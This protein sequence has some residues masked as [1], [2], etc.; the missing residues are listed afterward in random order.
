MGKLTTFSMAF[1]L[2]IGLANPGYS[3]SFSVIYTFGT[4]PGDP[5]FPFS[6]PPGIVIQGRD[7]DLYTTSPGGGVHND[8]TV[9]TLT[10]AGTLDVFYSFNARQ[11]PF[12]QQPYV[13]LALGTD[14]V[15]YGSTLYGGKTSGG[16]NGFGTVFSVTSAGAISTLYSFSGALDGANP[17]AP[18]I[19]GVDGNW[20]GTTTTGTIP[21]GNGTTFGGT[22]YKLT[23]AGTLTTLYMFETKTAAPFGTLVQGTDGKFY[24]TSSTGG[25]NQAG[26]IF[27]ITP[28][29]EFTALYTF[30][31]G[32]GGDFPEAGL[33]QGSDGNFYG[34]TSSGTT[35]HGGAI[36]RITPKGSLT[37]LHRFDASRDSTDG[38]S[39]L[40]VVQAT[41][42]NLYGTTLAGGNT[43]SS[44][45]GGCGT[46][47]RITPQ[48]SNYSI[49]YNFNTTTGQPS[50]TPMQHTSGKLYAS[51]STPSGHGVVYSLDVGL[52]P[53]VTFLQRQSL[54]KVGKTIGIFGQGFA[55]ASN[56]SFDGTSANFQVKSDTYLITT[57]PS[58][59]TTGY[60]TITTAMGVLNSSTKFRIIQ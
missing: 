12:L 5:L 1:L 7:G 56:V 17:F 60:V 22:I 26:Q 55:T 9:F 3:Q 27:K 11:E 32:T 24:G 44:C 21:N 33:I 59:A 14:G 49:L 4:N 36:F 35:L 25:P 37:V 40:G 18:P 42:G 10:P 47:Y 15:F 6:I 57:V 8:G 34:T 29:G 19:Q 39:P 23:P 54:G 2:S 13:G 43:K 48:G 58:G 53:F 28:E 41:D 31:N 30:G 46:I 20:Y 16:N 45:S 51:T 52:G 38:F 50:G